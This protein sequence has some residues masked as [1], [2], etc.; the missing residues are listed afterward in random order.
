MQAEE[1]RRRREG[2]EAEE[3]DVRALLTRELKKSERDLDA[4][5]SSSSEEEKSASDDDMKV[6]TLVALLWLCI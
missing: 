3:V 4:E 5:A 2:L 6:P 1:R